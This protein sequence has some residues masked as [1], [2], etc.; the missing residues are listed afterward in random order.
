MISFKLERDAA[1]RLWF[2][3]PEGK[4]YSDVEPVRAFPLSDPAHAVSILD[5]TG[6]ELFYIDSLD[7]VEP[8]VRRTLELELSQRE[9]VPII[10]RVL[11][12]PAQTEPATW[13]VETDRGVT[14]FEIES[15]D[16]VHRRE[17]NRVSIV[18]RSGL[19]YEIPDTRKLDAQSRDVLDRFL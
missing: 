19:R 3:S 6:R 17:P 2:T 16:S 7:E 1:R 8:G 4:Q 14:T 11:N 10:L 15:E 5:A 18:D 9:F 12:K 13:K